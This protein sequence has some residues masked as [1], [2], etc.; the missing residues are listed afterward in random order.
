M[1][2]HSSLN[3]TA[4]R[5]EILT[6]LDQFDIDVKRVIA[7]VT[8]RGDLPIF[9]YGSPFVLIKTIVTGAPV[10]KAVYPI[11]LESIEC[12]AHILSGII[13]TVFTEV[14]CFVNWHVIYS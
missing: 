4:I 12:L 13:K 3:N 10:L 9:V 7:S 5:A 2:A 8:D 14:S 1:S 11:G 6:V